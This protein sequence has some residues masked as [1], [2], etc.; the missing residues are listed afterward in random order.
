M[1]SLSWLFPGVLSQATILKHLHYH[2]RRFSVLPYGLGQNC[3]KGIKSME[4][5]KYEEKFSDEFF[6]NA[7]I[8]NHSFQRLLVI[9]SACYLYIRELAE[10]TSSLIMD[11]LWFSSSVKIIVQHPAIKGRK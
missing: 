1:A 3:R 7:E 4:K 9:L 8:N 10:W 11:L 5:G 2:N 6:N